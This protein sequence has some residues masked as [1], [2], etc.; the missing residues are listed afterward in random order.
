M[1]SMKMSDM[2][3][4]CCS[5]CTRKENEILYYERNNFELTFIKQEKKK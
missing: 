4:N 3:V 1:V 5:N 2:Y